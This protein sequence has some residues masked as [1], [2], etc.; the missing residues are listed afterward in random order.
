MLFFL[1]LVFL[2]VLNTGADVLVG[3]TCMCLLVS[4]YVLVGANMPLFELLYL[5]LV[6]L[7]VLVSVSVC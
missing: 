2:L 4:L 7:H 3:I 6:L 1:H 5:L